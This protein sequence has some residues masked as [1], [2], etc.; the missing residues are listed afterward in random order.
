MLLQ[1]TNYALFEQLIKEILN[2]NSSATSFSYLISQINNKINAIN[3]LLQSLE[4]LKI[5]NNENQSDIDLKEQIQ[6]AE[7]KS[8]EILKNL[9]LYNNEQINK[10]L[11]YNQN[12]IDNNQNNSKSWIWITCVS[13]GVLL[14]LGALG[15]FLYIKKKKRFS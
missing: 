12:L 2:I 10:Q 8:K 3:N 1:D 15:I 9:N 6:D 4:D 5:K 13:I 14:T 7:I 11:T